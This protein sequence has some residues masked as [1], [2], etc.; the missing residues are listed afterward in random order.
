M[1]SESQVENILLMKGIV[2]KMS[3]IVKG[4]KTGECE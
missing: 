1:Q 4:N 3:K 2:R